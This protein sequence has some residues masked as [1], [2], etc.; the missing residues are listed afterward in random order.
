MWWKKKKN[1]NSDEYLELKNL[2]IHLDYKVKA[3]ELELQLY[4]KK[5]KASKGITKQEEEGN[6]IKDEKFNNP[7]ILPT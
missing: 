2:I 4:V 1:I 3:L 5:L 6:G 7:V